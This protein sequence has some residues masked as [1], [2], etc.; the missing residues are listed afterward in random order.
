MRLPGTLIE[1]DDFRPTDARRYVLTHYHAD[2]RRGL[3]L[4]DPR[5]IACSSITARL[6]E[7]LHRVPKASIT[8]LDPGETLDLGSGVRVTAFDANHCPGALMLLFETEGRRLLHTGDFRYVPEHDRHAALF[9]AI[10]VLFVDSTYANGAVVTDAHDHPPQDEAIACILDLVREHADRRVF[11][12]LYKIGKNRIVEAIWRELGLKTW[13]TD[14]YHR[15]YELIGLSHCVT[16]RASE[17]RVFG[18]GMGVF[19]R[20]FHDQHPG[21]ERDSIVILPTGWRAGRGA[22]ANFHY[23]PY[24]EHNGT[25]ELERFIARVNAREVVRINEPSP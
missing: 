25:A 1:I 2:H 5:P 22:G 18:Y 8:T 6:L 19:Q 15:V 9:D 17:T 16:R 12:G 4:G 20:W 11:L 21:H 24:S 13:L 14:E 10:D 3:R 23:V 7:G